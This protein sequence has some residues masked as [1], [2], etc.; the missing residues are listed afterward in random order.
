MLGTP[1]RPLRDTS[2]SAYGMDELIPPSGRQCAGEF[3]KKTRCTQL[4]PAEPPLEVQ[5]MGS[6]KGGLRGRE[7]IEYS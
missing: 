7:G 4:T 1:C 6:G 5:T 2:W 3:E